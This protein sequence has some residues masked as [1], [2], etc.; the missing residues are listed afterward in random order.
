[1]VDKLVF[2]T[3][4]AT[5]RTTLG[6]A[7]VSD[8]DDKFDFFDDTYRISTPMFPIEYQPTEASLYLTPTCNLSCSYCYIVPF[9]KEKAEEKLS[10]NEWKSIIFQ[11][12]KNG[13][14]VLKFIGG[15]ALLRK[16]LSDLISYAEEIG[17]TGVE[18]TTNGTISILQKN[19]EALSA[20]QKLS[21]HKIISTSIDSESDYINDQ[22]RGKYNEVVEGIKFLKSMKLPV[23]VASVVTKLNSTNLEDMARFACDLGVDAYQFNNLVPIFP[24]QREIIIVDQKEKKEIASRIEMIAALYSGKMSVV[25]RF[26]PAP[27]VKKDLFIRHSQITELTKSSLTGCP[28]GTREVY[29]LPNGKLVACPMFIR[30]SEMHSNNSLRDTPFSE[31]WSN[32]ASIKEF[33]G[34]VAGPKLYGKC[35]SCES[36]SSCK[37]GCRAMTFYMNNTFEAQDPRCLF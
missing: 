9:Y 27:N 11:L 10:T 33:R 36:S 18:L 17:I 12:Y 32:D 5:S 2:L 15:E 14:R 23:S 13:V 24:E 6:Y 16:D 31:I 28:A 3:H 1:M 21:I 37:G 25:N 34:H 22:L 30:F 4:K 8:D 26:V 19:P 7:E 35:A 29:V 20:F